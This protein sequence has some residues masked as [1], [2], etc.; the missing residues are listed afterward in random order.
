M[1]DCTNEANLENFLTDLKALLTAAHTFRTM[2]SLIGGM[3]GLQEI[4]KG[5]QEIESN[6]FIWVDDGKHDV[7]I[8]IEPEE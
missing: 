6:G 3:K 5:W 8:K 1:F 4:E 7:K 2:T